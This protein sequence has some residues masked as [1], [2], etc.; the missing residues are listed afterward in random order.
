MRAEQSF[1]RLKVFRGVSRMSS[2]NVVGILGFC[3]TTFGMLWTV[4]VSDVINFRLESVIV[5]SWMFA[6]F[7]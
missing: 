7:G 3:T 5:T 4:S 2:L 1:E 6:M